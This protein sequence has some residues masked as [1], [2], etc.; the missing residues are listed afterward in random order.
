M[1]SSLSWLPIA[2]GMLVLVLSLGLAF[3]TVTT[4]KP[5]S[6]QLATSQK[7]S[8][9]AGAFVPMLSLSP[10]N[11]SF[12]F[13]EGQSYPVG[14]VLDSAGKSV[15][16]VDV[17]ISFDPTKVQIVGN[18]INS[19]TVF[20][21]NPLNSVDVQRG[22]IRF[23]VLTFDPKPVTGILGTFSF[24]VLGKGET[25]FTIEFNEGATTDSNV[26][27]HGSAVDVLGKVVNG[28]YIFN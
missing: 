23:S 10:S 12:E 15:D 1:R 25:N 20:A 19:T 26:A 2:S 16:G 22:R 28:T 6:L 4:R 13:K 14:I 24:K 5:D 21:E 3:I 27:E 9:S 11:G 7:T 8:V 17:V 18:K